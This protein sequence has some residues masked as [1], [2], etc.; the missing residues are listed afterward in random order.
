MHSFSLAFFIACSATPAFTIFEYCATWISFKRRQTEWATSC[1]A[2]SEYVFHFDFSFVFNVCTFGCS[3]SS[4]WTG[5]YFALFGHVKKA[6]GKSSTQKK[7]TKIHGNKLVDTA[8]KWCNRTQ[9]GFCHFQREFHK[10]WYL[11]ITCYCPINVRIFIC[12]L[13][14]CHFHVWRGKCVAFLFL[15]GAT[16]LQMWSQAAVYNILSIRVEFSAGQ[17][18]NFAIAN[19]EEKNDIPFRSIV[20]T[21]L[22]LG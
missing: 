13:W 19:E 11:F 20:V 16:K 7:E 21:T 5:P 14:P 3:F 6:T 9:L 12:L 15:N 17:K 4:Y 18:S 2:Y 10:M 22:D 1:S 8:N